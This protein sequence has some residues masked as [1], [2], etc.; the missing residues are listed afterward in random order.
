[1]FCVYNTI[2]AALTKLVQFDTKSFTVCYTILALRLNG[3]VYQYCLLLYHKLPKI[4]LKLPT[5]F[6]MF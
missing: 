6:E 2:G 5:V 3:R 4:A 1:M